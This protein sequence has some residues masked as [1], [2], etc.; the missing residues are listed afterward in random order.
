VACLAA[1]DSMTASRVSI[2]ARLPVSRHSSN[3]TN[4]PGGV[5]TEAAENYPANAMLKKSYEV[6]ERIWVDGLPRQTCLGIRVIHGLEDACRHASW[7]QNAA[8]NDPDFQN[9]SY[10]V[11]VSGSETILFETSPM[12]VVARRLFDT[13]LNRSRDKSSEF[14]PFEYQ[15][16]ID[17]HMDILDAEGYPILEKDMDENT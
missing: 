13:P 10:A 7:C 17:P 16:M 8:F 15:A 12:N 5:N 1:A 6:F 9:L 3:F 2:L 4:D 14:T 11:K